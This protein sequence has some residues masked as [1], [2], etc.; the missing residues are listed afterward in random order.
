MPYKP[1]RNASLDELKYYA[2][3]RG[4]TTMARRRPRD[5]DVAGA[6]GPFVAA[7]DGERRLARRHY[8]WK[9][10]LQDG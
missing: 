3:R 5:V 1:P 10:L 4:R 8:S 7:A 9:D 6:D 2:R